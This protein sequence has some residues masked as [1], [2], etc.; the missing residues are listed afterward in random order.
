MLRW[1]S[2]SPFEELFNLQRDMANLFA[3]AFGAEPLVSSTRSWTPAAE[4]FYRDNKLYIRVALPGVDPKH[5]DLSVTGN[6][7]TIK[8]ERKHEYEVPRDDYVFG[9]F[10]YGPF[11]RTITLPSTVRTDDIQARYVHG[12]LEITAPLAEHALPRKIQVEVTPEPVLT[13]GR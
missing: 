10:T 4:A 11:E 3:R 9:E 2:W 6:T 8:G 7:L 13:A 12:V 5:V 1:E